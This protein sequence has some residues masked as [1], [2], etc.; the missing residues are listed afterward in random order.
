MYLLGIDFETQGSDAK[1]TLATEV[2][3]IL[4]RYEEQK[5]SMALSYNSL[6]WKPGYPK[7]DPKIVEL[8]GI[9]DGDLQ[10]RGVPPEEAIENTLRLVEQAD[11]VFA[12]K[13]SFDRTVLQAHCDRLGI[14]LPKREWICT[15]TNFPWPKRFTCHK[16]SHLAYEHGIMV[17]PRTLHRADADVE[18]M[19]QL[20][21]TKY[22]L[23]DVIAYAR[24]PWIYLRAEPF[25]PWQDGGIQNTIAKE[26]G[27]TYEQVKGVDEHKWPKKWVTRVKTTA[28][29]L[30]IVS[31]INLSK[32]PF[33][34]DVIEG[35]S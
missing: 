13:I 14:K 26:N 2:G 4:Y 5:L 32:S 35:I 31:N 15:L 17:D 21:S 27:F 20:I 9:S 25:G 16:L 6:I 3:A 33:R 7:Q 24:K 28:E 30:L 29:H 11:I 1:T 22:N 19:M 12:H 10:E 34:V 18:L 8:T 23:D